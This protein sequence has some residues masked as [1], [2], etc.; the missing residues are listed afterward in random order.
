MQFI[1]SG[2]YGLKQTYFLY[3][4]SKIYIFRNTTICILNYGIKLKE[5]ESDKFIELRVT[6]IN[7]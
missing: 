5:K 4:K 7:R 6:D 3:T 1:P 2:R